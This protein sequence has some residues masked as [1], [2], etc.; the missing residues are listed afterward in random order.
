MKKILFMLVLMLGLCVCVACGNE[1]AD[2]TVGVLQI[3]THDA[4]D[5]ATNG[6][7]EVIEARAKEEGKT[8]KFV[9]KNPEGDQVQLTSMAAELVESCDLVLGNATP[10]ATALVSA[11]KGKNKNDLPI[12]FTSVTDPVDAALVESLAKPGANITGTSDLNPVGLQMDLFFD[13]DSAIDK[14]GF[15]YNVN[16]SNSKVQCDSAEAYLTAN[17]PGVSTVTKTVLDTTTITATVEALLSEGVKG[18]YIPTDNLLA[19]NMTTVANALK[20]ANANVPVVCGE[21]GMVVNGGTFTLS[22]NYKEL[23]KTTGEMANKILFEGVKPA[24]L[25]VQMQDDVTKFE[26]AVNEESLKNTGKEFSN[27]FKEKYGLDK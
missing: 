9:V 6:F 8:V 27:A 23:G 10:A 21:S 12:L 25:P 24:D 4:L 18:I 11:A 5:A 2:F 3:Q 20:T 1:K 13:F 7:K 22:I 17:K 19:S 14:I 26:F 15:L 16:E